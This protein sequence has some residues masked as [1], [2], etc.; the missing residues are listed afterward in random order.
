M[1]LELSAEE[2]ALATGVRRLCQGRFPM[3]T[4]RA[5]GGGPGVERALGGGAGVER[6]LWRELADAGA[7][8]LCLEEEQGGAGLGA[9]HA[10]LVFEELG[11]ALV[12]GPLVGSH[13]AAGVLA[14]AGDGSA[15]VGVAERPGSRS[16]IPVVVEHLAALDHL[17]VLDDDGIWAVAPAQLEARALTPL[18][19]LTPVHLI[20]DLPRGEQVGGPEA[21]ARWRV[22]GTAF[23]SALLVGLASGSTDLA[24]AY[25]RDRRQFDRPI[26]S[27]QAVKHLL[28]DMLTRTELARAA[29]RVAG[30]S[31]D[32]PSAGDAVRAVSAAK[33][34]AGE[35]ALAN[36]RSCIQVHGGM[37]FTWDVDAHLYLK[38]ARV[39]DTAFGSVDEQAETM[40]ALLG[41]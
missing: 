28:A 19:P 26:G 33:L 9:T 20:T 32:D 6:A 22:R 13:L 36:G 16:T 24:V 31:L 4:V 2:E 38:R 35:A 3:E 17:A 39:L 40:A 25:A 41:G 10:V 30:A 37:G 7:F 27:F 15:V 8:S 11:R 5:L 29:V 1:D 21:A 12:P 18:D 23:S 14:G 34:V